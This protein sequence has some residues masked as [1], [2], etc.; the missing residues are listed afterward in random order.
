MK[1]TVA[2]FIASASMAETPFNI[3][4]QG[5]SNKQVGK[6]TID[7]DKVTFTGDFDPAA[8]V[9][10]EHIAKRWSQQWKN[11]EKRAN[12]FDRFMDAMDTAKEALAAGTPLDLESLFKGE[13]ASAM[14]ATMFAGE[15]VRSGARNYL[16]LGYNVPE[17]GEFTVTI[18]R[19]EGKTPGERIA[20]LEA[21]VDQ[22]NGEC[23]RLINERDALREEQ[24]N[25][26]S[27]TRAAADIYF[28]LVEECQI[29]PGGSLV[30]YVRELQEKAERCA[31]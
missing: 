20:E 2:P 13:M 7:K 3:V 10:V 21:V 25:K 29:P 26:G 22:R 30:E 9:F 11:L 8:Q 15:F 28:Q 31:A 16:E 27:N 18:Q 12:E 14:F 4:F 17:M 19:K 5:N 24:L 6:I 1:N 23:V